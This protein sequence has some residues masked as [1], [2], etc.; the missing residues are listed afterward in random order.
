MNE[1]T[2]A[3]VDSLVT[4]TCGGEVYTLN[5][6]GNV[7]DELVLLPANEEALGDAFRLL[8]HT[9]GVEQPEVNRLAFALVL[10]ETTENNAKVNFEKPRV[11]KS[12][13]DACEVSFKEKLKNQAG[14]VSLSGSFS[15]PDIQTEYE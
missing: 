13:L 12:D 7:W 5:D 11:E 6:K 9:K 3:L 15:S 2:A 10:E 1:Y 4:V 14:E 8:G